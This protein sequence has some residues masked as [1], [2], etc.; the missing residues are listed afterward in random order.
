[1]EEGSTGFSIFQ[2]SQ[3]GKSLIASRDGINKT[4]L[5]GLVVSNLLFS[6]CDKGGFIFS[7]INKVGVGLIDGSVQA[8][9]LRVELIVKERSAGGVV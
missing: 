4:L 6:V 1:L 3:V 9:S 8:I 2:R 5:I 7:K